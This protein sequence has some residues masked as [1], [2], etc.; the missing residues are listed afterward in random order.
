MSP[1]PISFWAFLQS[2]GAGEDGPATVLYMDQAQVELCA[3]ASRY[4]LI[5]NG[6]FV[7]SGSPA[8]NWT[9]SGLASADG[10]VT[11]SKRAAPTLD[12]NVYS[13][14]GNPTG[15][16][17]LKQ[18]IAVGGEEG[19]CYVF[20]G[21]AWADSAVPLSEEKRAF[22]I[23]VKLHYNSTEHEEASAKFNPG[24]NTWQ[25]TA[26]VIVA[27]K[28]YTSITVTVR[29]NYNAN[30]VWFDGIQLYKEQFGSSYTYDED[31][32]VISV[33]DLQKQTTTYEYDENGNVTAILQ[34]NKAKLE[35]EYDTY[36]NVT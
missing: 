22:D 24:S 25:Y 33:V 4:N 20:S 31:G 10:L 1:Q 13:I 14:K 35:Y 8:Y 16:K 17:E 19:D 30:T 2:K 12:S 32:N 23:T 27:K 3:A 34:D 6:D 9:G 11:A 28:A 5:D 26:N 15:V 29:Y 18:T 7:Y 36:I 21:W